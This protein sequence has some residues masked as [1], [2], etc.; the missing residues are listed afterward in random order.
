[1]ILPENLD[2]CNKIAHA[3]TQNYQKLSVEGNKI[4]ARDRKVPR[5]AFIPSCN[6]KVIIGS[7]R[8]YREK[9]LWV[10]GMQGAPHLAGDGSSS[11]TPSFRRM[12]AGYAGGAGGQ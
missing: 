11:V 7:R 3:G 10:R 8:L 5:G 4:P 6:Q 9:L 12:T 2:R 1:M